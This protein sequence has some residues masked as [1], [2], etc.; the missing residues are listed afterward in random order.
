M[1]EKEVIQ[2]IQNGNKDLF[3]NL[4]NDYLSLVYRYLVRLTGDAQ[5]AEDLSQ[6]TFIRVWK[7]IYRFEIDKP[8]KPWLMRIA[9]N[10]AYDALK[11]RKIIPFSKLSTEE[12]EFIDSIKDTQPAPSELAQ[13]G[14][15]AT[16][17]NETLTKLT[18]TEKEVLVLHYLEEMPVTEI[19][20]F[21]KVPVETVRTRLRRAR[22]AFRRENGEEPGLP[23]PS[24]L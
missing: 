17:V 23:S 9:R 16:H 1:T 22:Q 20:S 2:S 12:L 24:V 21:L 11:K 6:E 18:D 14:E 7:N 13:Q 3:D 4:V 10:T 8:F 5:L 19:A 15:V